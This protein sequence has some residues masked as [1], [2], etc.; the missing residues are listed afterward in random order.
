MSALE[1]GKARISYPDPGVEDA[2]VAAIQVPHFEAAGWRFVE[3]DREDWPEDLQGSGRAGMVYV[4]H[5]IT[6]GTAFVPEL[7]AALRERGWEVLDPDAERAAALEDKTVA[8]L[9]D[10]A[11]DRGISPI[12]TT[13]ADLI[14]ALEGTQDQDQD[15]AGDQPA[16][17]D[18]EE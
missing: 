9:R 1:P 18:E 11:K 14:D 17:P 2:V 6:G 8:E 7:S 3:G 15:E 4:R 5:P 16:Q 13:K 12:P 10:L